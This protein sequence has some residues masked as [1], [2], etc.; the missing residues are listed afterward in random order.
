MSNL[1]LKCYLRIA[2]PYLKLN[3]SC[4]IPYTGWP[5]WFPV[6]YP[7]LSTGRGVP[8][9]ADVRS[10]Q[11]SPAQ[12]PCSHHCALFTRTSTLDRQLGPHQRIPVWIPSSIFLT[13]VCVFRTVWSAAETDRNFVLSRWSYSIVYTSCDIILCTSIV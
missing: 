10:T 9:L 5:C 4:F 1:Q 3:I 7:G 13:T 6:W 12:S 11:Y 8:K 2:M